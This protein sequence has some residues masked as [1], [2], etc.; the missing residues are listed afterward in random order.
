MT[1]VTETIWEYWAVFPNGRECLLCPS[2]LTPW[3]AEQWQKEGIDVVMRKREVAKL[4]I[5]RVEE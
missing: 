3:L 4:V 1:H 2:H 5:G